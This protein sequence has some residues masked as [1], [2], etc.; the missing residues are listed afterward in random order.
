MMCNM[1]T[2]FYVALKYL[3]FF[4]NVCLISIITLQ[5]PEYRENTDT[6]SS[7]PSEVLNIMEIEV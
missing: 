6:F 4:L 5:A 3:I 7:S 2:F 1:V